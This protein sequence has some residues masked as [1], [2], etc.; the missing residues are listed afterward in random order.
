LISRPKF[1]RS[2]NLISIPSLTPFLCEIQIS[3][4]S[5]QSTLLLTIKPAAVVKPAHPP[6][7]YAKPTHHLKVVA[8]PHQSPRPHWNPLFSANPS[9]SPEPTFESLSVDV[10]TLRLNDSQVHS[11]SFPFH[12]S[13]VACEK[14]VIRVSFEKFNCKIGFSSLNHW[15]E[16]ED[17]WK[18][19]IFM[20][21]W[22]HKVDLFLSERNCERQWRFWG[23]VIVL[24][25][26]DFVFVNSS[27]IRYLGLFCSFQWFF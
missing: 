5:H 13:L 15:I 23:F 18:F 14:F 27:F 3:A 12:L 26:D 25:I 9:P 20:C 1:I 24:L 10:A 21:V 7:A 2:P 4:N 8:K 11:F 17:C 16:C 6:T 19:G 22:I